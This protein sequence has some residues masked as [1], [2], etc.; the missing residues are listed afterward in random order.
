MHPATSAV[1]LAALLHG[2]LAAAPVD[3]FRRFTPPNLLTRD[4]SSGFDYNDVTPGYHINITLGGAQYSVVIDTGSSDLWVAG[5]V[6]GAKDTGATASVVYAVGADS[7]PVQTAELKFLDFTIPD[8]A[9]IAVPPANDTPVG[10]GLVGLGPN[11]GSQ[12]HDALNGPAGDTVIDRIFRQNTSTPNFLTVLL[13][14]P[15]DAAETYKGE[16]TVGEVLPTFQNI[17]GQPKVPVT[18][19]Q[20]A[21]EADQHFSV[22]LDPDGIIGPDGQAIKTTSNSSFAPSHNSS[23]LVA[24]FDTGFSLPQVPDYVAQAIYSGVKGAKLQNVV[25]LNGPTWVIPC[26]AEVNLTFKIGGQAYPVHP[27]DTN[28]QGVDDDGKDI[29]YGPYQPRISGAQDPTYDVILGMAFLTNVYLLLDYGDFIDGSTSATAAPYVQLVSTTDPAA[30]HAD[31]VATRLQGKD[32]TGSQHNGSGNNTN[33]NDNTNDNNNDNNDSGAKGFFEKH[34]IPL[35]IGAAVAG[36][37]L[38]LSAA[39]LACRPRRPAYR[40]LADPAP[41]G[42]MQMQYVAGY[43]AP[44]APDPRYADPWGPGR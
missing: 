4:S 41:G 26:D 13:S 34:K 21:I 9:F 37:L 23:Q 10:F 29:C 17:T 44:P 32:T 33:N 43:H 5:A 3:L 42:D 28:Q 31:F 27:L 22:L 18:V 15:G 2:A 1:L 25:S 38:L 40:A 36:A 6:P 39:W 19:L 16:M 12:V 35:I 7:G 14:R 20:S 8:Q 24:V 11:A 30:A